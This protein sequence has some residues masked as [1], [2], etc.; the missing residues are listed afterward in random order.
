MKTLL[1]IYLIFAILSISFAVIVYFSI[2]LSKK[3]PDSK[4]DK[5]I[6]RHIIDE[7]NGDN[8]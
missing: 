3:Y 6:K 4:I 1:L 8:F 7:Y 5:F 2:F